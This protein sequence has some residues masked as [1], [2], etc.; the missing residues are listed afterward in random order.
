LKLVS[1]LFIRREGAIQW[2]F[3]LVKNKPT[4]SAELG[5]NSSALLRPVSRI[6]VALFGAIGDVL[7]STPLLESLRAAYPAA[8]IT[9]VVGSAAA[10]VLAN[11]SLVDELYVL[12]DRGR[13][14][15]A[16]DL[17]FLKDVVRKKFDLAIC[18]SRSEKLALAFWL[19]R[20]PVRLGYKPIRLSWMFTH[21]VDSDSG[22]NPTSH[23]TQYFLAAASEL[24][25]TKPE[26]IRLHYQVTPAEREKARALLKDSG[27][28]ADKETLVAIH[29]GTSKVL[30]EKRRWAVENF[31]E[32]AQHV[33][34]HS[35]W[36]VILLGGQDEKDLADDFRRALNG[37]QVDLIGRLSLRELAAVLQQSTV[38]VHNDSSPLHLAGAVG[39]PVLAIFGYQNK[40][41]WGPLGPRDRVVR[42]DLPCSPCL[43]EFQCPY[44]FKCIR[45]LE[46]AIVIEALDAMLAELE[47][48]KVNR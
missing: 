20:V 13:T 38:L 33:E 35:G 42:R 6:V 7:L 31:V 24:G 37:R 47:R 27:A 22:T 17:R 39:T 32:V 8:H 36:R 25:L 14:A 44:S 11:L 10:P 46:P 5:S 18:L 15:R 30:M 29:P 23:R 40:N 34:Q 41:L 2:I 1:L 26:R 9:Y 48:V 21:L 12:P 16:A 4:S 3:D 28:D 19:A 43:P 45:K